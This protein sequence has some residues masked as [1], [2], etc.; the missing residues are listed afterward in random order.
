MKKIVLIA[1][2]LSP[3]CLLG[4]NVQLHHDFGKTIYDGQTKNLSLRPQTTSTIEHFNADKFGS[5]YYFADL[6]YNNG[7]SA[8]Y[9]EISRE[10]CFWK[11]SP[12]NWLSFHSEYN[13]GCNAATS[14]KYNDAWLFGGTYSG[15]NSD[16]SKTWSLSLMYKYIRHNTDSNGNDAFHNFQITGVWGLNFFA[17]KFTFSGFFDFWKEYYAWQNTDYIFLSEPQ[18]WFNFY[19]LE[20]LKDFKLSVG[21]EVELSNNFVGK[22]FYA[23]PTVAL[24]WTF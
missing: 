23:V 8:A 4:Q 9:W 13:G 24:K 20:R 5:W 11:D 2:L 16:F 17:N 19:A 1:A 6:D 3:M 21:G 15:H 18:V 10:L 7:V 22:G 12:L 14:T